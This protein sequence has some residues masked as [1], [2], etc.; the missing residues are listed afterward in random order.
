MHRYQRVINAC[1]CD[2]KRPIGTAEMVKLLQKC[3]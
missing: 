2:N 1:T 3:F